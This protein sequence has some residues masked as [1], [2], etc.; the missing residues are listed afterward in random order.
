MYV[1][2]CI[3]VQSPVHHEHAAAAA[4][5]L[6]CDGYEATRP[7]EARGA[8][9]KRMST[10]ALFHLRGLGIA[11]SAQPEPPGW[12]CDLLCW[13]GVERCTL[14][15]ITLISNATCCGRAPRQQRK[16]FATKPPCECTS[17]TETCMPS[18]KQCFRG[19]RGIQIAR[20][21]VLIVLSRSGSHNFRKARVVLRRAH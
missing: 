4:F 15:R 14:G 3:S 19:A 16:H 9:R 20:F 10:R 5:E 2:V 18:K 6:T 17:A 21:H 7:R 12:I 1:C 13:H 11:D 8:R